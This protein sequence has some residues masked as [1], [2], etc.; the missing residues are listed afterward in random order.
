MCCPYVLRLALMKGEN[1]PEM[2][3]VT[4]GFSEE[5]ENSYSNIM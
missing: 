2:R 4:N 3:N 5:F 1:Q